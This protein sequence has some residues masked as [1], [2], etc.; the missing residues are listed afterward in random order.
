MIKQLGFYAISFGLLSFVGYNLH[1]ALLPEIASESPVPLIFC[2]IFYKHI[3]TN[4]SFT[5]QESV[6][7]LI[8]M[9]LILALEVFFLTKL[10]KNISPSKNDR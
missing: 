9:I 4:D 10:L 1:I 5:N 7:L 8:P 6:N 2:L 3:F